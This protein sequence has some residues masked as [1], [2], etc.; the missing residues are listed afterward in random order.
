MRTHPGIALMRTPTPTT[1]RCPCGGDLGELAHGE[2][3]YPAGTLLRT[4][5]RTTTRNLSCPTCKTTIA[6]PVT[7]HG[8]V[9]GE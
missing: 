9:C 8:D 1:I 3:V 6:I 7:T 4:M 2:A 5:G